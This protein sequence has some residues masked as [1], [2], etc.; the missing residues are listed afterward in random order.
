M[1]EGTIESLPKEQSTKQEEQEDELVGMAG[2]VEE[3]HR[4]PEVFDELPY[5]ITIIDWGLGGQARPALK[6]TKQRN[7]PNRAT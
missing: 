4:K 2:R 5:H 1:D 7:V 6:C 3:G